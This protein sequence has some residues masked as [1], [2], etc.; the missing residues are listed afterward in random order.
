VKKGESK[1]GAR[2]IPIMIAIS[3][4]VFFSIRSIIGG[5]LTGL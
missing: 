3:F 1:Q 2:Y 4:G 5:I